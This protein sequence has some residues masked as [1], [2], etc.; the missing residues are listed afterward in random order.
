MRRV[1]E[2]EKVTSVVSASEVRLSPKQSLKRLSVDSIEEVKERSILSDND[3]IR[4]IEEG[5]GA[6]LPNVSNNNLPLAIDISQAP[7]AQ[8]IA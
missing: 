5:I 8:A 4:D 3:S 6:S 1:P 2:L 7:G